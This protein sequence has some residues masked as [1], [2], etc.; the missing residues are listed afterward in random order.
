MAAALSPQT[1]ERT[2]EGKPASSKIFASSRAERGVSSEGFMTCVQP[3]A[4][5]GPS[6]RVI[7]AAG[8]F[9][10]VMAAVTPTGLF[11]TRM[12]LFGALAGT[13]SP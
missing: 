12:R 13:V 6:L 4:I 3:A 8:K 9:H 10:G 5:A 1:T 2:P 7:M 11:T